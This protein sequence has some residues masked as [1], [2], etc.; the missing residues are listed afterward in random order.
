M[1]SSLA[2][3]RKFAPSSPLPSRLLSRQEAARSLALALESPL[4]LNIPPAPPMLCLAPVGL[5]LTA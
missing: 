2:P 5:Q 1:N 4:L 3:R